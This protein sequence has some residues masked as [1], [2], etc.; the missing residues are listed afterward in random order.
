MGVVS[1]ISVFTHPILL[2][3]LDIASSSKVLLCSSFVAL[4]EMLLFDALFSLPL[5]TFQC[6][7]LCEKHSL[8]FYFWDEI[9]RSINA[10]IDQTSLHDLLVLSMHHY[11]SCFKLYMRRGF[12]IASLEFLTEL[13]K[14]VKCNYNI[15]TIFKL[16]M[17]G[18][19]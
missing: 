6:F 11:C 3:S 2:I 1:F 7:I 9:L 12:M 16:E 18:T 8:Y 13:S 15:V 17:M 14:L 10:K 19:D 4:L 5:F